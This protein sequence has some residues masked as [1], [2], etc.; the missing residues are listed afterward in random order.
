MILFLFVISLIISCPVLC[1]RIHHTINT[2]NTRKQ[3]VAGLD[4]C[5]NGDLSSTIPGG[6][7]YADEMV[8]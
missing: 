7:V 5:R 4:H 6:S 1:S 8:A 2:I 3:R